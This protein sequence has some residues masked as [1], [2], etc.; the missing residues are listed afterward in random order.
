MDMTGMRFDEGAG[1]VGQQARSFLARAK[2]AA[3]DFVERVKELS[4][5]IAWVNH[6]AL[7]P[8]GTGLMV[9][10]DAVGLGLS[11]LVVSPRTAAPAPGD[12]YL[13][14]TALEVPP[15]FFLRGVRIGL[16]ASGPDCGIDL[17]RLSQMNDPPDSALLL[18]E[19]DR[20]HRAVG[21]VAV[22]SEAVSVDPRPG[23]V[24]LTL[25]FAFG[26]PAGCV[27]IR[28]LGMRLSRSPA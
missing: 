2:E 3:G 23:P 6:F 1:V 24:L 26:D 8:A 10:H 12:G 22:E 13:L 28:A 15:G 16:E 14:E 5:E 9:A 17:I 18:C 20:A 4:E 27:V 11:G 19:D 21:P 25:G 7:A